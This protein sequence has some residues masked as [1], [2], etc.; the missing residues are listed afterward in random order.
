LKPISC[1]GPFF[2]ISECILLGLEVNVNYLWYLGG[3]GGQGKIT[4]W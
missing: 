3:Y 2:A 1:R 4:I